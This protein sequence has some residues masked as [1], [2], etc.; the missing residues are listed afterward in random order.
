MECSGLPSCYRSLSSSCAKSRLNRQG[1]SCRLL[2]FYSPS[3]QKAPMVSAAAWVHLRNSMRMLNPHLHSRM[4]NLVMPRAEYCPPYKDVR[5]IKTL[6]CR[7]NLPPP[8]S[9][10]PRLGSWPADI[11]ALLPATAVGPGNHA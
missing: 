9:R 7:P 4:P 10:Y 6:P 3:S 1:L 8:G 11:S 5:G 2:Q